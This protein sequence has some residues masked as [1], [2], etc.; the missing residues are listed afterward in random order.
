MDSIKKV[1]KHFTEMQKKQPKE[2]FMPRD[3][4]DDCAKIKKRKKDAKIRALKKQ[5]GVYPDIIYSPKLNTGVALDRISTAPVPT[6]N[7]NVVKPSDTPLTQMKEVNYSPS[8]LDQMRRRQAI[9][10]LT[11]L[12]EREKEE[13]EEDPEVE[14]IRRKRAEEMYTKYKAR[15]KDEEAFPQGKPMQEERITGGGGFEPLRP[16]PGFGEAV[17]RALFTPQKSE[18]SPSGGLKNSPFETAES[19]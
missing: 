15:K 10:E 11:A 14:R 4:C 5:G 12:R 19:K 1:V 7:V 9:N 2:K 8:P 13:P 17:Q 6:I 18:R 3:P 16:A